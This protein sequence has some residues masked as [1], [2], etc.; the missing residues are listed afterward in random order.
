MTDPT[1]DTDID[2]LRGFLS[3]SARHSFNTIPSDVADRYHRALTALIAARDELKE[4]NNALRSRC[5]EHK[6]EVMDRVFV[7]DALRKR[8]AEPE[9]SESST[10]KAILPGK[11][12]VHPPAASDLRERLVCAIWPVIMRQWREYKDAIDPR[13]CARADTLEEADKMI[14]EM[15]KGDQP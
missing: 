11:L 5:K 10:V 7:M 1:N 12:I 2:A 14:A 15:R 8:V 4:E 3:L 6:D 9:A 13:G